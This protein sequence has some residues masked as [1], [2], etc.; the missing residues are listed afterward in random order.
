MHLRTCFAIGTYAQPPTLA[1]P[2]SPCAAPVQALH[3]PRCLPSLLCVCCGLA[4]QAAHCIQA[5][6]LSVLPLAGCTAHSQISPFAICEC[7]V[8]LPCLPLSVCGRQLVAGM[9][10]TTV[11]CI[12]P[13]WRCVCVVCVCV[14]VCA[15]VCRVTPHTWG[16]SRHPGWAQ[17]RVL[18][19]NRPL[20]AAT[21][22]ACCYV[23]VVCCV[24]C[25]WAVGAFFC[26]TTH[27]SCALARSQRTC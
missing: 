27:P 10:H 19:V 1:H 26:P 23:V 12:P 25:L 6:L 7:V 15:R 24:A 9:R 17:S 4:A 8:H 18:R 11:A 5:C 13:S 20:I 22:A 2:E 3:A 21:F 14:C 16:C